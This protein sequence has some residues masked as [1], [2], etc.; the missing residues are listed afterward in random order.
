VPS[1]LQA[2]WG[3]RLGADLSRF[4]IHTSAAS[5]AAVGGSG[6]NAL[7]LGNH[8]FFRAGALDPAS[9]SGQALLGH[10]LAHGLQTGDSVGVPTA[11][12]QSDAASEAEADQVGSVLAE[13]SGPVQVA[14]AGRLPPALRGDKQISFSGKTITVSDTYVIYGPGA[15]AA[16]LAKFQSALDQ[17]YNNA[18]LNYRG[19]SVNF[20]LRVRMKQTVTRTVG[21]FDWESTDWSSDSDTSLFYI[22]TETGTAGGYFEITL[23]DTDPESTIAHEVGHYLSD[24]IGYFSEGYSESVTSRFGITE[25]ETTVDPEARG[26]IMGELTG[27]VGNFSLGGI[28]DAAIDAHEGSGYDWSGEQSYGFEYWDYCWVAREVVPE[29]WRWVRRYLLAEAP[30]WLRRGYGLFGPVLAH[31][32]A[33]KPLIKSILRPIFLR[34]AARGTRVAPSRPSD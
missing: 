6:A 22:S 34:L 1:D 18:A 12:L 25:R 31:F 3:E 2:A 27:T 26:D 28:L 14:N 15:D 20:N 5:E 4:R 17:Y 29:H 13:G 24:R 32:I 9:R 19:Y 11:G 30:C 16:F 7:N 33:D 21:L 8:L 10:E 23:Y